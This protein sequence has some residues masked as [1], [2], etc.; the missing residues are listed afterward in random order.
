MPF[1]LP[2]AWQIQCLIWEKNG[3][4]TEKIYPQFC[5]MNFQL[6]LLIRTDGVPGYP[7]VGTSAETNRI[8]LICDEH[9]YLLPKEESAYFENEY[10]P[11]SRFIELDLPLI[12]QLVQNYTGQQE[13]WL[14][15]RFGTRKH[16][17]LTYHSPT[18]EGPKNYDIFATY[19]DE[20]ARQLVK[21]IYPMMV[22]VKKSVDKLD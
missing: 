6:H 16:L 13:Y 20:R 2:S 19:P 11:T 1:Y 12:D 8:L 5:Q 15:T 4:V 22:A 21:D 18:N 14:L 3:A 10:L 9:I 7:Y 17:T